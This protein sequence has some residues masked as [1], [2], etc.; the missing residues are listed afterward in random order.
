MYTVYILYS[1]KF[2]RF[3]VGQ[4]S[5]IGR[6]LEFHNAGHVRSTQPYRPWDLIGTVQKE[7]RADATVLERKLKNLNS[8]D[9]KRFIRK[10]FNVATGSEL[11]GEVA[12]G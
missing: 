6:R 4:T 3:Y 5:D 7:T 11:N 12:A 1:G 10:Y 9:L 8:R 2:D